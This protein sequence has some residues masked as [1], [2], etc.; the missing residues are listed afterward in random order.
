MNKAFIVCGIPGAGKTTYGK[1]LA[2]RQEAVFLDIDIS[3][4]RLI[5]LSLELSGHDPDDRDGSYFKK[6]FRSPIYEQLLD[7]AKDNLSLRSVV[8]VGPFTQEIKNPE[9]SNEL[10]EQLGVPVEVHYVFCTPQARKERMIRRGNPRDEAKLRDWD[11][12][13]QYYEKERP[14]ACPHVLMDNS[15]DLPQE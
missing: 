14:P 2:Q 1:Q 4:E 11:T 15:N 3:T 6:H 8:I 9:W 7:I 12:Y 5:R 10:S 13:L